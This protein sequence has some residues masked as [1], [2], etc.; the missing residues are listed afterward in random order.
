MLCHFCK[1]INLD[2]EE[3]PHYGTLKKLASSAEGGCDLCKLICQETEKNIKKSCSK[4]TGE[5]GKSLLYN[6]AQYNHIVLEVS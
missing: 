3:I 5:D 4:L 6:I 1:E 2:Q